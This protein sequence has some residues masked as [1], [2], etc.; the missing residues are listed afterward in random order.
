VRPY[1]L[2]HADALPR[3]VCVCVCVCGRATAV[4]TWPR[5]RGHSLVLAAVT[6]QLRYCGLPGLECRQLTC[7]FV[8]DMIASLTIF[9]RLDLDSST[10]DI[11]HVTVACWGGR[12]GS[13]GCAANRGEG[14]R[15]PGG[16]LG[17]FANFRPSPTPRSW[18]INLFCVAVTAFL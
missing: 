10:H 11:L 14:G 13:G 15:A 9:C 1:T 3:R 2:L 12:R 5:S 7:H 17:H 6:T 4:V 16:G 8:P 18:S